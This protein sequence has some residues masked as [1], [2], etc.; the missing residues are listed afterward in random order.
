MPGPAAHAG[1]RGLAIDPATQAT[2]RGRVHRIRHRADAIGRVLRWFCWLKPV[3][4]RGLGA[5]DAGL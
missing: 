1:C 5:P 4:H 3:C 2:A